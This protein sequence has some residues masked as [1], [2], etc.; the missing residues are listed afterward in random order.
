MGTAVA[1]VT[2]KATKLAAYFSGAADKFSSFMPEKDVA[3]FLRVVNNAI[4]RDP[5]IAEASTQSVFLECQ[6]AAADGLV[7]DGREAVLNRFLTNKRQKV[8]G[9]WVD[10]WVMEVVYIP[11]IRG[12]RKIVSQAP[13]IVA[14]DAALVYEAEFHGQDEKGRDRFEYERGVTPRLVHRPIVVGER[15]PVVAAYSVVKLRSGE[16]S[17]DLLT[18]GQLDKIKGRTKARK[19]GKDG[20]PGEITGPWVSDE[21]EMFIKT[22]ARHHFKQLPLTEKAEAFERVDGLYDMSDGDVTEIEPEEV[23][24]P[25]KAVANKRKTSAAA[26]LAAAAAKPGPDD[27]GDPR[28]GDDETVIDHDPDEGGSPDAD[29]EA[30][31]QLPDDDY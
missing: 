6:K 9:K 22:V 28:G 26:K 2:E 8:N 21:D 14:W 30:G 18:R 10:N 15:G 19:R 3:K 29:D 13:Q 25:P 23:A 11:M 7:L 17:V 1:T 20:Q 27:D 24:P 31:Q 12:L 5:Q 16:V 4:M